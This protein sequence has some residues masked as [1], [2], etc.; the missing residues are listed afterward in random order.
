MVTAYQNADG[1]WVTVAINYSNSPQEFTL[2]MSDGKSRQWVAYR[3]SDV[4]GE[5][6]KPVGEDEGHT[7]LPSRSITTFVEK[8][9]K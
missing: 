7:M 5:N 4:E 8:R 9:S 3:T 6:L 2:K 1:T